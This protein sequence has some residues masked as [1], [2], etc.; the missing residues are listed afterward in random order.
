MFRAQ[1]GT[2]AHARHQHMAEQ[3]VRPKL[4]IQQ[5]GLERTFVA[6]LPVIAFGHLRESE[7][8]PEQSV[9]TTTQTR[10]LVH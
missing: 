4:C 6:G 1:L 5:T 3:P 10:P 8:D 7:I 2:T 9:G